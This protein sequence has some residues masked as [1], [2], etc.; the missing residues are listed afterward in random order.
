M[1]SEQEDFFF[2]C[3]VLGLELGYRAYSVVFYLTRLHPQS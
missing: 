3:G 1:D 2:F